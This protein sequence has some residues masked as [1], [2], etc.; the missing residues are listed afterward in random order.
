MSTSEGWATAHLLY[1]RAAHKLPKPGTHQDLVLRMFI[2]RRDY[3][4][5]EVAKLLVLSSLENTS[6]EKVMELWK[7]HIA[8]KY[9]WFIHAQEEEKSRAKEVLDRELGK[10]PIQVT[11]LLPDT[12]REVK[13]PRIPEDPSPPPPT[14]IR[15]A[16]HGNSLRNSL[17]PVPKPGGGSLRRTRR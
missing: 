11:P 3:S 5:S 10:G 7:E 4:E 8:A 2:L 6:R 14:R 16:P 13:L 15:N 1:I 9:P 17:S 12:R